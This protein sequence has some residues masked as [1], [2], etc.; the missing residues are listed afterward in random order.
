MCPGTIRF[1]GGCIGR[2][3]DLTM[4]V[5]RRARRLRLKKHFEIV[6][7]LYRKN[8]C[9]MP[10]VNTS[11]EVSGIVQRKFQSTADMMKILLPKVSGGNT[12]WKK[13]KR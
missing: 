4:F 7:G 13:P 1:S 9:I 2:Y 10:Y 3:A 5:F 11:V 12:R 8:E 6:G